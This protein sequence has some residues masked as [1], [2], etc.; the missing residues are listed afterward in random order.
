VENIWVQY[1]HSSKPKIQEKLILKYLPLVR[2]VVDRLPV[3]N[4]PS[5]CIDDLISSG[6]IGLMKALRNFNPE[7]GVKFSTYAIPRI[8]GAI[9][10]ELRSLD[11]IPRSLRKKTHLLEKTYLLLESRLNRPPTDKELSKILD[12]KEDDVHRLRTE[13]IYF[14]PLRLNSKKDDDSKSLMEIIPSPSTDN[15]MQV[16]EKEET[17]KHLKGVIQQL[18][19]REK[20]VIILYYYEELTLREIGEILGLSESRVSQIHSKAIFHLRA[21]LKQQ[22]K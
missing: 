13:I 1:K 18:P 4:L 2:Y 8:R 17:K 16:I 22:I 12:I 20:R 10:D 11:W 5:V 14:S 9:M 6:I 21:K 3:A 15:P 7:R 19:E